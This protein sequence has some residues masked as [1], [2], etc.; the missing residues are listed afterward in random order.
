MPFDRV[1]SRQLKS[2][3]VAI[4]KFSVEVELVAPSPSSSMHPDIR[5]AISCSSVRSHYL[6]ERVVFSLKATTLYASSIHS[7]VRVSPRFLVATSLAQAP[8]A[9]SR[10]PSDHSLTLA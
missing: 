7:L 1:Q 2:N 3:L 8:R 10:T 5:Q 6:A 4:T 9:R